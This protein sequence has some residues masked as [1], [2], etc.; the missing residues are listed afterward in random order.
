M[1]PQAI[2]TVSNPVLPQFTDR[3]A[4]WLA[5]DSTTDL[6]NSDKPNQQL[7]RRCLMFLQTR[8]S[9]L[10]KLFATTLEEDDALLQS[11]KQPKLN[12][13]RA[14][15]VQYRA[16]EKRILRAVLQTISEQVAALKL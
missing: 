6:L 11:R 1:K 12:S 3:L 15:L 2:G 4:H 14:M 13:T 7:D 9:I 5:S 16:V 8:L 10:L